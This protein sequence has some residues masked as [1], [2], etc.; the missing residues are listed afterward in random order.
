MPT[1][2]DIIQMLEDDI[3]YDESERQRFERERDVE[4]EAYHEGRAEYARY[5]LDWVLTH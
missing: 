4:M 5:M 2:E 1:I 3:A